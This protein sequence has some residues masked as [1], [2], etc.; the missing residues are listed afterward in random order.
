MKQE[1]DAEFRQIARSVDHEDRLRGFQDL[2]VLL[3]SVAAEERKH[4][5]E[6]CFRL[7]ETAQSGYALNSSGLGLSVR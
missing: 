4:L 2:T 6:V 5:Q 7:V 1:L 3:I